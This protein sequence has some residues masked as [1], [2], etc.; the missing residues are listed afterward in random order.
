MDVTTPLAMLGGLSPQQFMRR[1][2]HKKPLLVR[3]AFPDL[4]PPVP[5][6]E[7][8]KLASLPEVESRLVT[9]SAERWQLRQGPFS[10]RVL[11]PLSRPAWTLLVQGLD[12]HAAAAHELLSRFRFVPDARLDDLMVS[13]AS[14]G[15]GV[16]PHLDAYDVFLIQVQGRRHWRIG[17]VRDDR[18]VDGMP[19]KILQHFQP[20]QEWV[21]EPG[22]MLYLPPGVAHEGVAVGSDCITCSIGFRAPRYRELLDPWL[23]VLA[24][25]AQLPAQYRDPGLRPT[26]RPGQLPRAMVDSA[27]HALTR[28]RPTAA[29]AAQA[30]LTV[31]TEPKDIVVFDP[32]ARLPTARFLARA[33]RAGLV[34]DR[35]SRLLYDGAWFGI[36]G[37]VFRAAPQE[38][39][40]LA[41]L[42][43]S[44]SI[45]V[46]VKARIEANTPQPSVALVERLLQW[47]HAGWLHFAQA[48]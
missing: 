12:L 11:P 30:L 28:L 38:R 2:W 41:R 17:R 3:Q 25:R 24:E 22:D 33:K 20:E 36:N 44:G 37:E 9:R 43:D 23:D 19:L 7:L 27:H 39:V 4:Q 46:S 42:A 45:K 29:D 1:H 32:P 18:L 15:G 35:R 13:Y 48:R 16:G 6:A 40:A 47:Y 10:R 14:D 8:F 21:L 34:L 31:L 5:R 26:T